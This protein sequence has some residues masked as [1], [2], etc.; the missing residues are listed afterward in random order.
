MARRKT[1]QR[2]QLE[3]R[4]MTLEQ[5]QNGIE[6]LQRRVEDVI[7]VE[8]ARHDDQRVSNV[9]SDMRSA[10]LEIFGQE[11]LEFRE[12][13]YHHIDGGAL[14]VGMSEQESQHNFDAGIPRSVEMLEG[15]IKRLQERR[16]DLGGDPTTRARTAFTGMDLHDRVRSAAQDLY[17][18]GHYAD[19]VFAA[20]KALVNYV[21][22]KS[23][24][25]E[26]DGTSLM[27]TVFSKKAPVL[28]F[29]DLSDQTKQD[30]QEGMMHLFMG[31]ALGI[32]N[33]RG[34][35]FIHDSAERALEY[36]AFLSMLASRVDESMK[37]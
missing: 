16:E 13:G 7:A 29:S 3:Q 33:P 37:K 9:E 21:Q 28:A 2:P 22:E 8:G 26:L 12:H 25:F 18:D 10:I 24:R 11:S 6:K 4:E 34:H 32:R 27:T 20:S 5:I 35:S 30:E 15:L 1:Q 14:R 19:A 23:G 31:A 36:I 17:T